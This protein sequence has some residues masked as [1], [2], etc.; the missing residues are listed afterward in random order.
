MRCDLSHFILV[1]EITLKQVEFL[2]REILRSATPLS[3]S[4]VAKNLGVASLEDDG[5]R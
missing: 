2:P 4:S 3:F 5:A 1:W